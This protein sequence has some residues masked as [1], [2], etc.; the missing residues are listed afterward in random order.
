MKRETTTLPRKTALAAR[1]WYLVDAQ[2]KTVGRLASAIA[3]LLRGKNNPAFSSH[4]DSGD[5]VVVINARHVRFSGKKLRDKIYYR[6]TEYPGGIRETSA[7]QL[8][9]SHP[10]EI[11]RKA[12]A[13]MLPKTPLGRHLAGKVKIYPNADHPHAA[14]QPIAYSPGE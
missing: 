14:Q 9:V 1:R 4:L 8:L 6:H 12:V 13:G 3:G 10:E 7:G 11:L 2:G 5:F